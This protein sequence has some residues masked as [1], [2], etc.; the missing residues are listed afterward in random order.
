MKM[1]DAIFDILEKKGAITIPLICK[2]M[3]EQAPQFLNDTDY[4]IEQSYIETLINRKNEI[5]LLNGDLV[6]I[7]PEK[8][9]VRLS[10]VLHGYPGPE[11]RVKVDFARNRFT[12]FEWH[13]DSKAPGPMKMQHPGSVEDF[14]KQMYALNVWEW[15]ED[16][17]AEGII[18][19]GTSWSVKLETKGK[20]Y[21]S[22]GLDSFPKEWK[23][24]CR[25]ISRLVGKKFSC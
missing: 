13:L 22:G 3:S 7:R 19:D 20:T 5:F 10:A 6:S 17:Q 14:K 2:E 1:Y 16:Y 18:V 12:Y 25:S 15:A 24:F 9:P 4:S 21:E 11:L 23:N 8:E